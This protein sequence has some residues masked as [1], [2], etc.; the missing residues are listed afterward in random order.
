[1]RGLAGVAFRSI[2]R[3]LSRQCHTPYLAKP[4]STAAAPSDT[5]NESIEEGERRIFDSSSDT[6]F[7]QKLDKIMKPHKE[8][9]SGTNEANRSNI[10]DGL[11]F[12][13]LIDGVDGKLQKKAMYFEMDMDEIEDE[14]TNY[15]FRPDISFQHTDTYDIKDLDLKKPAVQKAFRKY[16]FEV[17]TEEALRKADFRNV[18]FLQNFITEAGILK[19]R[20]QTGISAKAQRKIAREIKTARAFGLMPFTTMGTKMFIYDRTMEDLDTDFEYRSL[21][22]SIVG[23]DDEK[24][25]F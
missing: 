19:K 6:S 3:G 16:E 5:T 13:S 11:D 9:G 14:R 4:L 23:E 1:M 12:N 25:D 8:N 24:E 15:A 17:T 10:M 2:N 7:Y 21:N 18:R 20:R 22:D